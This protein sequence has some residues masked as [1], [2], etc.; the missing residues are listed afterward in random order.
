MALGLRGLWIGRCSAT[1]TQT[2]IICWFV[3][4]INWQRET[5]NVQETFEA[6][7]PTTSSQTTEEASDMIEEDTEAMAVYHAE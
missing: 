4:K 2:L 1:I 6:T 7:E 3:S 5:Q